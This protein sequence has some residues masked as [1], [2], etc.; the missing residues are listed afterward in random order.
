MKTKVKS[1]RA[2]GGEVKSDDESESEVLIVRSINSGEESK[3]KKHPVVW[4]KIDVLVKMTT[5]MSEKFHCAN[6]R[7]AA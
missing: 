2:H 1:L 7:V 3:K 6:V 4:L 5:T